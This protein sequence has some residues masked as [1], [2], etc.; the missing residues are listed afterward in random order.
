MAASSGH[1]DPG[2]DAHSG[3]RFVVPPADLDAPPRKGIPIPPDAPPGIIIMVG[4]NSHGPPGEERKERRRIVEVATKDAM[5][6]PEE[7]PELASEAKRRRCDESSGECTACEEDNTE[8]GEFRTFPP[9]PSQGRLARR[10]RDYNDSDGRA[11]E[12][13]TQTTAG[14]H[15]SADTIH[16]TASVS[17]QAVPGRNLRKRYGE[18]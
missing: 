3:S 4:P 7:E 2:A 9:A 11:T 1:C 12:I 13:G 6:E 17:S 16:S 5:R 8:S 18:H 15:P 10:K 14:H